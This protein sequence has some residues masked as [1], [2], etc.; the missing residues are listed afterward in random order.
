MKCHKKTVKHWLHRW[1]ET[2]DL[3]DR[4]RQAISR[5]TTA[6]DDQLIVDLVQQ[7]VDE[8]ITS[9][10]IQQELQNQGVNASLRTVQH[11][12]VEAG[13]KYS[14]ILSKPLLSQQHQHDRLTWAQSMTSYDWNKIILTDE[15]TI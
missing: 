11:R 2:K 5:I 14:R 9:K 7:D 8:G 3:S 4:A 10:Q 12:L 1:E 15:T 6:E 13:F